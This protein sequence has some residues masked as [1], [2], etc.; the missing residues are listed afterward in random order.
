[1]QLRGLAT[2]AKD[3]WAVVAP[4]FTPPPPGSSVGEVRVML[5]LYRNAGEAEPRTKVWLDGAQVF[6]QGSEALVVSG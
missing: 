4:R 1:M 3:R 5:L 6:M 2:A